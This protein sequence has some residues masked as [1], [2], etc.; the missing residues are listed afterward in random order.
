MECLWRRSEAV[1][2]PVFAITKMNFSI[3]RIWQPPENKAPKHCGTSKI[4]KLPSSSLIHSLERKLKVNIRSHTS[5]DDLPPNCWKQWSKVNCL[6]L[7]PSVAEVLHSKL[8][9]LVH[10]LAGFGAVSDTE[11][12]KVLIVYMWFN[13]SFNF[14]K[15][16]ESLILLVQP[17]NR[18]GQTNFGK[19]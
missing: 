5:L 12:K 11:K 14:S 8:G 4:P 16:T 2:T 15:S 7:E 3:V 6:H 18:K 19:I 9:A 10:G 1:L 13:E 17:T